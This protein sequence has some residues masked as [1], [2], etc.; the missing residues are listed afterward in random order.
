MPEQVPLYG[1]PDDA[2][3]MGQLIRWYRG[4]AGGKQ[5]RRGQTSG[6][7]LAAFVVKSVGDDHLGCKH[8]DGTTEGDDT[9]NVAKPYLLRR[10][11]FDGNTVAG[12]TYAY[13]SAIA[14]TV[15]IGV[16][17]ESQEIVPVYQGA[18]GSYGG[19]IIYAASGVQH[20]PTDDDDAIVVWVDLNLDGR[21]WGRT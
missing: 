11:P 6:L 9:I 17:V 7:H 4:Q 10:T 12:A 3:I 5:K 14:R 21:S 1:T 8:W 2:R 20:E 19:D 15:T 16:V 18:S 13:S